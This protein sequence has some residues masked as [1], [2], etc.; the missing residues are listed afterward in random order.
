MLVSEVCLTTS[1]VI[2]NGM[3][4]TLTKLVLFTSIPEVII[5]LYRTRKSS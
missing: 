4:S 1:T 5:F 3:Y 2:M